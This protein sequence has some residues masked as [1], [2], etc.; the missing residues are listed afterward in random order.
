MANIRKLAWNEFVYGGHLLSLGAVSIVFTS[1]LLLGIKV[2]WDCLV[3]VYLGMHSAYLYNRYKEFH[4]DYLT[5]PERTKHLK[6][7]VN[8]LPLIIISFLILLVLILV[9]YSEPTVLFFGLFLLAASLSYSYSKGLKNLTKRIPGFKSIFVSLMWASL[10]AFL[11]FYYSAPVNIALFLMIVFVFLRFFVNTSSFDIKDIESD[12]EEGLLTLAIILGKNKLIKTLILL[13]IIS[14]IPL[15]IGIYLKS[16]PFYSLILLVFISLYS[17][18][19]LKITNND[20]IEN[21]FLYNVIIDAE[22]F[23]WPPFLLLGKIIL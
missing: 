17:L 15:T 4:K 13:T 1:A 10:P 19:F 3:A 5:N 7:I 16:F 21:Y 12:K 23:L 22:F 14:L 18:F 9:F 11:V 20:K 2:T 8:K 6:K